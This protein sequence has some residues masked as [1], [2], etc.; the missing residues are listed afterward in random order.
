MDV[1]ATKMPIR[2]CVNCIYFK[3]CGS[4]TRTEPCKGR[5]TR[6]EQKKENKK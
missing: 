1:T 2:P 6:K 4:N 5:K 3:A